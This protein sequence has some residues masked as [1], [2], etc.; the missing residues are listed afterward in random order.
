MQLLSSELKIKVELNLP[1]EAPE[2]NKK[3][4]ATCSSISRTRTIYTQYSYPI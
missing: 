4:S 2:I 3:Q 1:L